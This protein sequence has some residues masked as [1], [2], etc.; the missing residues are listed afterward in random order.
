MTSFELQREC[1]II[2]HRLHFW[3]QQILLHF[4]NLV[5]LHL[6]LADWFAKGNT[7]LETCL[8]TILSQYV[9]ESLNLS[10]LQWMLLTV[11]C[12]LHSF[13]RLPVMSQVDVPLMSYICGLHL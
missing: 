13:F 1:Y 3:H 5:L 8:S 7:I 10:V 6:L 9:L 12:T 11:E 4:K 2:L